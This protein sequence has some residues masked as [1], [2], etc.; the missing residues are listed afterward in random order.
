[1]IKT[2]HF[3]VGIISTNCYLLEDEATGKIAVI[4]PGDESEE[5]YQAIDSRGGKLDYL[6]LTHG[7]YDHIIGAAALCR[8][9]HPIVCACKDEMQLLQSGMYNRS[10][11][12]NI[13]VNSFNVDRLLSDGDVIELGES[14]ILFVHTPGHTAG[15]GCYIVDNMIFSGD[16]IFCESVGRTDLPTGNTADIMRSVRRIRDMEGDYYI[17]PGHMM[18]STL[19]HERKYN[20]YMR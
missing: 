6:L 18:P 3:V 14:K 20:P 4:D 8:R 2:E 13:R 9:Y 7:H 16:T 19:E 15:S 1:M 11:V 12:H 5:L 10:S 17:F